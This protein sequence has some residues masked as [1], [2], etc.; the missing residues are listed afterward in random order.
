[1]KQVIKEKSE[2]L[3]ERINLRYN[4][5][6]ETHPLPLHLWYTSFQSYKLQLEELP[7]PSVSY[8]TQLTNDESLFYIQLFEDF[9]LLNRNF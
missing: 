9:F 6:T 3:E 2:N 1:M 7:L 5:I 4:K 8:L